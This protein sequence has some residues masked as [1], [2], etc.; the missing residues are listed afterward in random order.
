MVIVFG[1]LSPATS[2]AQSSSRAVPFVF[3]G[4]A[5]Q[6]GGV[7]GSHIV[8][9]AW[10]GGMGLPDDGGLNSPNPTTAN[11]PHLGLLLSKN[12]PT[13]DCSSAGAVIV[14]FEPGTT[15][16]ELGF[17]YRNGTHCGAGAPRF[18]VVSTAGFT[19]FF[20]C[21]H[22][23]HTPATQD[24][25]QWTHVEFSAAA[26]AVDPS[27]VTPAS[28]DAPPIVF[29]TT[30]IR[31]LSIVYDEGT[32][33]TGTEDPNGVGLVVMDNISIND[34][35]IRSGRGIADGTQGARGDNGNDRG[36]RGDDNE[37]GNG[38]RNDGD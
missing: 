4:T 11:D 2:P 10:L 7:A 6:C 20:G 36:N 22:G 38:G 35:V 16:T 17:D 13:P 26:C 27:C 12:G 19:Y 8:T 18:N 33:V 34:Q 32:E 3:I 9:A 37:R 31:S 28:A 23:L 21:A 14:G 25:A 24:P 15:L 30:T 5:A 29:G 1:G